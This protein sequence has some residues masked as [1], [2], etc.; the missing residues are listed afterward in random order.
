MS[1]GNPSQLQIMFVENKVDV[2]PPIAVQRAWRR[3][4]KRAAH[5]P[6]TVGGRPP[7]FVSEE[8]A[9]HAC[10]EH[11]LLFARTSTMCDKHAATWG[12]DSI[13]DA[14]RALVFKM[15]RVRTL[16]QEQERYMYM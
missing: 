10:R 13:N 11:R 8:A 12:G 5:A 3:K 14:M 2:L 15:L 4:Q 1:G 7:P 9:W 16:I 6:H